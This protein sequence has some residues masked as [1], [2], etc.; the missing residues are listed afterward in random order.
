MLLKRFPGENVYRRI[1]RR[2]EE[3]KGAFLDLFVER[4]ELESTKVLCRCLL[5]SE[6]SM[7]KKARKV[8]GVS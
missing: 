6:T 5:R 2:A 8:S 7:K 3:Q 4:K 1:A